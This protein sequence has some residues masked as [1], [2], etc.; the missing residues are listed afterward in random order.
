[1]TG[2]QIIMFPRLSYLEV[3]EIATYVW[4]ISWCE[5]TNYMDIKI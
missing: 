4:M 5:Y 1:M 3:C 2:V